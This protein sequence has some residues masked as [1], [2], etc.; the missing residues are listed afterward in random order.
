M[1]DG[2]ICSIG[3]S[4]FDMRSFKLN[5]EVN[6]FIYHEPT[7]AKLVQSFMDDLKYSKK[8]DLATYQNRSIKIR[9]KESVSRLL[10]PIL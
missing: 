3:T 5:F 7:T 6:A 2:K 9:I 1:I 10:S 8:L 4:N